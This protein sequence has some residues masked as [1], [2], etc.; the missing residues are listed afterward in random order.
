VTRNGVRAVV[1]D[2]WGTLV[3][4][5]AAAAERMYDAMAR[6]LAVPGDR[7]SHAWIESFN[8]RCTGE[9]AD[10]VRAVT[11]RLGLDPADAGVDDVIALRL[12][13]HRASF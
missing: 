5:P 1:F 11:A 4:F 9:L 13:L 7:F 6:L 12:S 8:E 3:P 2:L 10:N